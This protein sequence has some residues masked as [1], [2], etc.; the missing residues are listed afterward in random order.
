MLTT[1]LPDDPRFLLSLWGPSVKPT[2]VQSAFL[3]MSDQL[4]QWGGGIAS[5]G[6]TAVLHGAYLAAKSGRAL[7]VCEQHR[8]AR[9][10]ES[11]PASGSG[12]SDTL[13]IIRLD[14]SQVVSLHRDLAT[15]W[16]R[17]DYIG[18]IGSVEWD[19]SQVLLCLLA[20]GGKIRSRP[21]VASPHLG[22]LWYPGAGEVPAGMLETIG[23]R[24]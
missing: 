18:V 8:F 2:P 15:P 11:W 9:M 23:C 19:V 6:S 1:V 12:S 10:L 24:S 4:L 14:A 3:M 7:L 22:D 21:D 13:R 5:G 16:N 17:Y 20:P